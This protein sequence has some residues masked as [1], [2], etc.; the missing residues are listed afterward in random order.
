MKNRCRPQRSIA[1]N[2]LRYRADVASAERELLRSRDKLAQLQ[3]QSFIR[4]VGICRSFAGGI[5]VM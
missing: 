1:E 3:Q 2:Y 4:L 5:Q